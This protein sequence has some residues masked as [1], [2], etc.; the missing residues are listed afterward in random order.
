MRGRAA[1]EAVGGAEGAALWRPATSSEAVADLVR[2][3]AELGQRRRADE[4]M[5]RY[6]K[7]PP[8]ARVA[9]AA[10]RA[11]RRGERDAALRALD[12]AEPGTPRAVALAVRRR[13]G[14]AE[15]HTWK[16]SKEEVELAAQLEGTV[17][18]LLAAGP[19]EY[20]DALAAVARGAGETDAF[21]PG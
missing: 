12:A 15:S 14:G 9:D 18:A 2:R 19:K 3:A 7:L 4:G 11:L 16:Y 8:A 21:T 17:A 20:H 1:L 10:A 6:A 13:V 5:P